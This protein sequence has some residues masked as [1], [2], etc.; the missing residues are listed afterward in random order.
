MP[1]SDKTYRLLLSSGLTAGGLGLAWLFMK[2]IVPSKE[3]ML[4]NLPDEE[5]SPEALAA[6]NRRT[7]QFLT[8][9]DENMKSK[10]PV[11]QVMGTEEVEQRQKRRK[12]LLKRRDALLKQRESKDNE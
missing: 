6:A 8:V 10:K 5:S 1:I 2:M 3:Q 4:K 12:E 7:E 11:W 9:L